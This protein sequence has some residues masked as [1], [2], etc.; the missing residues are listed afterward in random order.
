MALRRLKPQPER[1]RVEDVPDRLLAFKGGFFP[2]DD[3]RQ[4]ERR[5]AH[6]QWRAQRDEWLTRHR[7]SWTELAAERSR[8][9]KD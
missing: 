7:F 9:R 2:D 4:A 5:E 8:R 6:Q 3:H 1:M